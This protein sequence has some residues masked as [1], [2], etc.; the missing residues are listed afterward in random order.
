MIGFVYFEL[1]ICSTTL[2]IL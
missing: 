2:L 1:A